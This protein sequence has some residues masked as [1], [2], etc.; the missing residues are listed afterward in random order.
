MKKI[1]NLALTCGQ[2]AYEL[3]CGADTMFHVIT[4]IVFRLCPSLLESSIKLTFLSVSEQFTY[5][6]G[7][8]QTLVL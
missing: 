1:C 8:I 4:A 3:G 5:S 6:N 2:I 7:K